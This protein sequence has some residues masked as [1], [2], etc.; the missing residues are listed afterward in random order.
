MQDFNF[1]ANITEFAPL[2]V[3]EEAAKQA[4]RSPLR[5]FKVGC[6]VFDPDTGRILSRGC[7]HPTLCS[8]ARTMSTHAEQ[9]AIAQ[10]K[11]VVDLRGAWAVVT[12]LNANHRHAFSSQSCASCVAQMATAG[13]EG[14]LFCER[15]KQGMVVRSYTI[16]EMKL[17]AAKKEV[18]TPHGKNWWAKNLTLDHPESTL[19]PA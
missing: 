4:L 9:H 13:L 18:E 14:V 5:R 7:A 15:T 16:D 2:A 6:S 17:K 11:H 10:A 8:R 3:W 19:I 1:P 12:V